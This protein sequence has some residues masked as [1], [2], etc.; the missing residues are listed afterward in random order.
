MPVCSVS[1]EVQKNDHFSITGT[2]V[3]YCTSLR[4]RADGVQARGKTASSELDSAN[5]RPCWT[6]CGSTACC[7]SPRICMFILAARYALYLP[8]RFLLYRYPAQPSPASM[9][10]LL[11]C[12]CDRLRAPKHLS[13]E[14]CACSSISR[15]P[16]R[17]HS[18][19]ACGSYWN[20]FAAIQ[21]NCH[22]DAAVMETVCMLP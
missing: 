21:A 5:C 12:I 9:A 10:V 16:K 7:T 1:M 13:G 3:I 2:F 8:V 17:N 15:S 18:S 6:C 4:C 22:A 14:I 20:V 19:S 11:Q